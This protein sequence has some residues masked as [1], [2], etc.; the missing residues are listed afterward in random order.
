SMARDYGAPNRIEVKLDM[1]G[2][3]VKMSVEDDGNGFDASV[4]Q[5][6][7]LAEQ[8]HDARIKGLNMLQDKLEL[9]G[10]VIHV[11][12]SEVDGTV[13]RMEIPAGEPIANMS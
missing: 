5:D 3:K 7:V 9:V 1:S 11:Q 12:S 13:V 4:L 8:A 6:S 2:D 10:G